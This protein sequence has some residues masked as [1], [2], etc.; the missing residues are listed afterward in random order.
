MVGTG[1][2]TDEL[3]DGQPVTVSCAKGDTGYIYAGQLDYA[4]EETQV[5]TMPESGLK[6]APTT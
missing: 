4:D 6:S 1:R 2:A 5:S 3:P